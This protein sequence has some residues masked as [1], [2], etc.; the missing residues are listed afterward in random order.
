MGER[1]FLREGRSKSTRKNAT[2][3][4]DP[5]NCGL[6]DTVRGVIAIAKT[7]DAECTGKTILLPLLRKACARMPCVSVY[8]NVR[9][10][11]EVLHTSFG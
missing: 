5:K 7:S 11:V 10:C 6:W 2:S 4:N 3:F 1:E 8:M 9:V